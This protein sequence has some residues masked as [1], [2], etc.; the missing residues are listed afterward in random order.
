M[1]EELWEEAIKFWLSKNFQIHSP[2]KKQ[3]EMTDKYL[4]DMNVKKED[5]ISFCELTGWNYKTK[6]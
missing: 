3:I 6:M 4:N 2:S 1:T 5:V